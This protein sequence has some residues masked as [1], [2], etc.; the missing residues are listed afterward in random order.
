MT[1]FVS[2]QSVNQSTLS[3]LML[4]YMLTT[5]G[6]QIYGASIDWLIDVIVLTN[7]PNI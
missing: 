7:A 6:R 2:G 4:L 5:G 1:V 3:M